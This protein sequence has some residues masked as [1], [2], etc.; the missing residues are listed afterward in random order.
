MQL[1]SCGA[2]AMEALEAPRTASVWLLSAF[3]AEQAVDD[4]KHVWDVNWNDKVSSEKEKA[5]M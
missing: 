1:P 5:V 4:A 3:V 2:A